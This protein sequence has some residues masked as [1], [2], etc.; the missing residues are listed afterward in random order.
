MDGNRAV[1]AKL[2]EQLRNEGW[3]DDMFRMLMHP[4]STVLRAMALTNVRSRIK[5]ETSRT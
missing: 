2:M 5:I 1:E 4:E 3:T